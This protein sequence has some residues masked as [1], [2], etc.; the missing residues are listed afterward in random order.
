M[1][2]PSFFFFFF[3]SKFFFFFLNMF[4][5]IKVVNSPFNY[6]RV[7]SVLLGVLLLLC[8]EMMSFT[9]YLQNWRIDTSKSQT[10]YFFSPFFFTQVVNWANVVF[11]R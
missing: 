6:H 11:Q 10:C 9:S 3:F 7:P 4:L 1:D 8:E 5:P 2:L